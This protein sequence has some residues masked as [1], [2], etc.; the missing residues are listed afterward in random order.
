MSMS[1]KLWIA[2]VVASVFVALAIFVVV[3][4]F[5]HFDAP[6]PAI[7]ASRDPRV[8]ERGRYLVEGPAHCVACHGDET[9]SDAHRPL[10]G[11]RAFELPIG[12][13]HAPNV[14]ADRA[15]GIGALS[16][17]EI[18]RALRYGVGRDG[19]ALVGLMAFGDLADPDVEA[20]VSYLR[21]Q[22]GVHR[23][24]EQNDWSL[25][26]RLVRAFAMRPA[27]RSGPPQ[28]A[29]E[30]GATAAYGA[31]LTHAVANCFGCH[32]ERNLR[33]GAVLGPPFAGGMTFE[34]DSTPGRRF[35]SVNL[36]PDPSTGRIAS[37]SEDAFVARLRAGPQFADSP[38]PWR[39]FARMSDDDL[40][41]IYRYLRSVPA[42]RNE[43][44][45]T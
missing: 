22:P 21:A 25:L 1:P 17:G 31:Y 23:E 42:V 9:R 24:I 19:R 26:G 14:T 4:P 33:T 41:A 45:R 39:A 11:G 7:H 30:P 37:W 28:R 38:M 32:T 10:I 29:V 27:P 13:V 44:P 12:R 6:V 18:A 35:V 34:S 16:D 15:T 8:I 43:T 20:I 5:R 40:R 3:R 2:L 36:T